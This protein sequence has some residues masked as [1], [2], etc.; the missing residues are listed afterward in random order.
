MTELA[1]KILAVFAESYPTSASF[2]GGRKL[3]KAGW[4]EIFPRITTD[5]AAKNDFLDAVEELVNAGI[6][7]VR[8]KRYRTGDDLEALYLEDPRSLFDALGMQSPESISDGMRQ[9]LDTP[10]WRDPRLRGLA[11]YLAPRLSAGHPVPV[12][13]ATELEDLGRLFM[14][15]SA[16]RGDRTM[17]HRYIGR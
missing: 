3:R 17:Y 12:R 5:V 8:W 10:E 13:N 14:L 15:S 11:E 6:L 7:S 4:H 16:R 1:R 9:V 2:K